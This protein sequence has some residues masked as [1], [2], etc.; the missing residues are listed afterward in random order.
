MD[1]KQRRKCSYK[2]LPLPGHS[3]REQSQELS[4]DVK[5]EASN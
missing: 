2:Q 3:E 1:H 5:Q 4:L